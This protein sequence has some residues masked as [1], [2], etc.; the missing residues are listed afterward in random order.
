MCALPI[1]WK[2]LMAGFC[3]ASVTL[4]LISILLGCGLRRAELS[5][6]VP[7]NRT[8]AGTDALKP[9]RPGR[10]SFSARREC[11]R[12]FLCFHRPPC[13]RWFPA[14]AFRGSVVRLVFCNPATGVAFARSPVSAEVDERGDQAWPEQLPSGIRLA[15]QNERGDSF[16][17]TSA[18]G[19]R[20]GSC[21]KPLAIDV[22]HRSG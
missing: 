12:A 1:S 19:W 16:R 15:E 4:P 2:K 22:E 3:A 7:G 18:I 10:K 20:L 11:L 5:A 6:P 8:I 13:P 14:Y 17:G 9:S 21:P